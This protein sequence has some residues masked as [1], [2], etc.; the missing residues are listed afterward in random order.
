LL[1]NCYIFV[2]KMMSMSSII[3]DK[4]HS[5]VRIDSPTHVINLPE[6][7]LK[8]EM[9]PF[10]WSHNLISIAHTDEIVIGMVKFQVRV[11]LF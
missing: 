7:V 8:V 1:L 9:S 6:Q 5:T 10:E 11:K 4:I 3:I 2:Y